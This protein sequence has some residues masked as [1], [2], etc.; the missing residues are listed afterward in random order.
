MTKADTFP[1]PCIDD[2][3]DQLNRAK[4]F[5]TLDLAAGNWQVKVHPQS[6]EKTAFVTHQGLYQFNVM[7]FGLRT[8]P[9]VFQRLMQRVLAGLNPENGVPFNSVYIDDILVFSETFEDHLLHLLSNASLPLVLNSSHPSARSSGRQ[10][11][12][13]ANCSY[14]HGHT[15]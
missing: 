12:F 4:Y 5:S 13:W 11:S 2:L 7:P 3:L 10:L 8:A 9:A 14:T 6:R 1:L 15:S